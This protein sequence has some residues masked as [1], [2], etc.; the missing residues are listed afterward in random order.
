MY[1]VHFLNSNNHNNKEMMDPNDNEESLQPTKFTSM[2][3]AN[4]NRKI[5]IFYS[6]VNN[7]IFLNNISIN[8]PFKEVYNAFHFRLINLKNTSINSNIK[9]Y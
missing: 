8:F 1:K 9:Q 2:E 5:S 6:K 7:L 3:N 4:A